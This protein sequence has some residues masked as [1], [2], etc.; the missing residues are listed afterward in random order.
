MAYSELFTALE[1]GAVDAQEH[2]LPILWA[3]KFYEVQKYLSVTRHAYSPLV[4][5][6]PRCSCL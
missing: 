1:T 4:T 5:A 2:P 6:H 3:A